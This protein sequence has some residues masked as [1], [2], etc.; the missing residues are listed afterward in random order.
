[1]SRQVDITVGPL[2]D[3]D[4]EYLEQRG[5]RHLILQNERMFPEGEASPAPQGSTV[6]EEEDITWEDEV[7]QLTVDE[8]KTELSERG[9][10]TTGNKETLQKRLID[11]GP[12]ED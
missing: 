3:Q 7:N 2:S 4:R 9:M 6:D 12:P 1:M 11:A 10:P 5:R 8:L